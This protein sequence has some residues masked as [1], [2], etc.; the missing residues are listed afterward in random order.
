MAY[1]ILLPNHLPH[2]FDY[3]APPD[4]R[5][6]A[7]DYVTVPFG[8]REMPGVVWG[9][10]K[11]AGGG[12]GKLKEIKAH[13][14]HLPPMSAAMRE[15]I[16]WVAWYTLSP[17]GAVL[18]MSLPLAEALNAPTSRERGLAPVL[19]SPPRPV[20]LTGEQRMAANAL[21]EKQKDGFSVTLLDGVTGSGKTEVYFEAIAELL[22]AAQG[23]PP[24]I[25]VLL[26]EI[27]LSVQWL[28][29]FEARFGFPPLP[30]H[31]GLPAG[32]R[33]HSWRAVAE[34]TARVVVGARS[35]LFLPYRNL[36]FIV[37]DEEHDASYKQEEGVIYHARDMAVT[38]GRFEKIPVLLASATP[39]LETLANVEAGKYASLR[40]TARAGVAKLPDII[41][42][43]M[44]N[45]PLERG[46]FIS[47]PLREQLAATLSRGEQSLL[48]LNR[49][50]YAPLLLCRACGHR[51]QC[52]Q[53]SAWMVLH[54]GKGA[55]SH[56]QCHHCDY[57]TPVPPACPSCQKEESFMPCGPGVERVAEEVAAFLPQARLQVMASDST[58]SLTAM[59]ARIEA[60]ER[61]EVD[62]M[63]GTQ[64]IAKGHHFGNLSLVGVVDA[65]MGLNGGDLRASERSW[66]LLHQISGRAGRESV[67]GRVLI[68]S[69]DPKHPVMQALAAGDRDSFL[70]L[71][72]AARRMGRMPPFTRLA[73]IIIEGAQE[74][75]VSAHARMLA[76]MAEKTNDIQVLGPAPAPLYLLRGHYRQRLLIRA[77]RQVN[78]QAW[79]AGWLSRHPA[80][81][82]LKV[83][84]DIDPQSFL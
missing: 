22:E 52:P 11:Y 69:F 32:R 35:A 43:D 34:G 75:Q 40:L 81:R 49:R 76:R 26:P 62:I 79:I 42:I 6:S 57:R 39:S 28:K 83:K 44:K 24:Q 56:L 14:G 60:M 64:M 15:F 73:A 30:W 9:E 74:T 5:L 23:D 1:E 8:S 13:H 51:F 70:A 25:L 55:H 58:E 10:G 16:D 78:V 84:V 2:G 33:K 27:S 82:T 41:L 68:Q 38:R 66:Q 80:P 12:A 3:A 53:C 50:G 18:K 37:I 47:Q 45:V 29:R 72:T 4:A 20:T 65:D 63:I 46:A 7:G 21:I 67:P 31:S 71:E 17:R 59:H 19:Y 61:G 77:G 48:F 54:K 36:K